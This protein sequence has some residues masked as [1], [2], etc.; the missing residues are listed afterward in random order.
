MVT[1]MIAFRRQN[2]GRN[3]GRVALTVLDVGPLDFLPLFVGQVFVFELDV[4]VPGDVVLVDRQVEAIDVTDQLEGV[5]E[6]A[7]RY[8][9]A[10]ESW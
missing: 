4:G 10:G 2:S 1:E 9:A 6:N 3:L 8:Q 5:V 7:L